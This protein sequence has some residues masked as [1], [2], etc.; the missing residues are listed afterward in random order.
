MPLYHRY[1]WNAFKPGSIGGRFRRKVELSVRGNISA[2]DVQRSFRDTGVLDLL[3]NP[4]SLPNREA[5]SGGPAPD[6]LFEDQQQGRLRDIRHLL[7]TPER[8]TAGEPL[9]RITFFLTYRCNLKCSFC[10]TVSPGSRKNAPD[11][12]EESFAGLLDTHAG[13]PVAHIHLT[14]GEAALVNGAADMVRLARQRAAAASMTSNGTLPLWIYEQLIHAGLNEIRVSLS[15]SDPATGFAVSGQPDA[16]DRTMRTV[17]ALASFRARGRNFHLVLNTLVT[18]GNRGTLP[19]IVRQLVETRPDDIK[20]ISAVQELRTLGDFEGV[21]DIVREIE[22][23]LCMLSP[24]LDSPAEAV[25]E[26]GSGMQ[27][28]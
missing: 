2:V 5:R 19:G 10:R 27:H 11:F 13:T 22:D 28:H 6:L 14:G 12:T 9:H 25:I 15:A 18:S 3:G 17:Q 4:A 7:D 1:G 26:S 16:W 21:R 20:L 24:P 8:L 23:Y